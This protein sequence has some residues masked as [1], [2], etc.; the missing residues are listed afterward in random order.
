[1]TN[2]GRFAKNP[3]NNYIK[4]IDFKKLAKKLKYN[5]TKKLTL[6]NLPKN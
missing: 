4:I 6:G 1:M 2:F 3:K 5:Y